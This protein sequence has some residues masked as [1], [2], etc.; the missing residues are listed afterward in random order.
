MG[1]RVCSRSAVFCAIAIVGVLSAAS[2]SLAQISAPLS[3]TSDPRA[4]FV[5]GNVT[6]CAGAG[7]AVGGH[8]IQIGALQNAA[9]SDGNVT[10]VV[11]PHI[12]G[13]EEVN[14]TTGPGVVV[15]AVIVKGGPAYNRYTNPT[16]LPPTLP[17]S[18]A[19]ISPLN[20]GTNVPQISHW[21]VCYHMG[22]PSPPGTLAV[23]KAIVFPDGRPVT[24][25]PTS[26][27]ALVNCND[28]LPQHQNVVIN[29][30]I[31][32]GRSSSPDLIGIPAGS[33]CTV[34]EQTGNAPVVSY[35]PAGADTPGVTIAQAEGVVVNITNDFSAVPVQFGTVHFDKVLMALPA[36]VIPPPSFTLDLACTDGTTAAV[37]LPG[38]GGPGSPDVA[39]RSLSLCA[40][41]EAPASLPNGWTV[42]YSLDGGPPNA[43]A[44]IMQILDSSTVTITV[45]N[46][47][48]AAVLPPVPS[49]TV[50]STTVP[51][52]TGDTTTTIASGGGALPQTGGG[53]GSGAL[54]AAVTALAIGCALV[55]GARRSA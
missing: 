40:L 44:P 29:F 52:T 26:F 20:G 18:Q 4:Q 13:G 37:T 47:P 50:P 30:N 11:T 41:I 2:T 9:A 3:T 6:T 34:A 46:D 16:F 45:I 36:G 24:P 49:T 1:G 43:T 28:N 48:T 51:S 21:F 42:S 55:I 27:S 35:D 7:I 12:G 32:G 39:V 53:S 5:P 31:G 8:T 25:L 17:S 54:L 19:Y 33:V 14:V 23:T 22:T 10:G 38:T 15:D